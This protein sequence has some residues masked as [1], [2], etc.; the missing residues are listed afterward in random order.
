MVE[1]DET[2]LAVLD[3]K[4]RFHSQTR[5]SV[6]YRLDQKYQSLE[7]GDVVTLTDSA[8]GFDEAV[9]I[10]TGVVRAPGVADVSFVTVPHWA[11]DALV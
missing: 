11:R 2:A 4:I 6:T 1:R 9:C 10:V 3:W 8:T 7:A 5:R